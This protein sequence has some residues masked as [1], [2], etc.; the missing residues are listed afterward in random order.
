MKILTKQRA[1]VCIHQNVIREDYVIQQFWPMAILARVVEL[2]EDGNM[3]DFDDT[4]FPMEPWE[5]GVC[6]STSFATCMLP[7]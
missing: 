4:Y 2:F 7:T 1:D 3:V 5:R 6:N